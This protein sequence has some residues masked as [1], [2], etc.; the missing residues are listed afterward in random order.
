MDADADADGDDG[1]IS[2]SSSALKCRRATNGLWTEF[3][4]LIFMK[5]YKKIHDIPQWRHSK[6]VILRDF[7]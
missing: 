7:Q 5:E 1:G 6:L 4:L 2:N 3:F